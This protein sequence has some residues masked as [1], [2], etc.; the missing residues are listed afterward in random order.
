VMPAVVLAGLTTATGNLVADR[1][2]LALDARP[3]LSG[4][5]ATM[6]PTSRSLPTWAYL[7]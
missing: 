7:P 1:T 3:L 2:G 4:R 6:L 5:G